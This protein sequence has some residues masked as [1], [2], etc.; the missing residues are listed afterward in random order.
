M[1]ASQEHVTDA[2]PVGAVLS[3]GGATFRVWAPDARSVHV[4][5]GGIEGYTP[6]PRDALVENP[7]TQHWTGFFPGVA[8]GTK[9]R[10][11][12]VGQGGAGPKRDPRARELEFGDF[13]DTDCIVRADDTYPWHDAGFVPAAFNDLVVYQF[14]VGVFY[15]T[16][17]TGAD[18]RPGRVARFLDAV[19]RVEYLAD[20]GVNAVQPLPF[21]EFRTPSSQ[22]YN[23]TTSSRPRWI[24]ASARLSCLSI[25][26]G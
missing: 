10:F 6:T 14:H 21:V 20:L 11:W 8:D 5:L 24:T 15:A 9:Y 4:A 19:D 13:H 2:T 18:R 7:R 26:T 16:D 22:G 23:G 25:S 1:P 12:V 17:E 3:A